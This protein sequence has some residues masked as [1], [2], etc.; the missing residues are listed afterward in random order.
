MA[1]EFSEKADAEFKELVSRYPNTL[2]AMLPVLHLAQREFGWISV[3]VMDYVAERLDVHPT[4]V[5]NAATF[6]TMYNKTPVGKCHVQVCTTL[7]CAIRGGY[8][9]I[10]HL[11]EKLGVKLGET[12]DD[13]AYTLSEAECL[14]SCGTAPMF[15]VSY[16][17][18]EIEYFENLDDEA[19]VNQVI[20]Q[21]NTRLASLPDPRKMH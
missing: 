7:S 5:L 1:V 14:A 6:Y 11:E 3:E 4:K 17:D 13:G 19:R 16:S 8:E 21:L 9:L 10:E 20:E 12:R 2:A 15:Q 18:G